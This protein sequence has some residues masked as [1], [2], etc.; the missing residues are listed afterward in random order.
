MPLNSD[1]VE[2]VANTNF[3]YK[4]EIGTDQI[5]SLRE[6]ANAHWAACNKIREA[7]LMRGTRDFAQEDVGEAMAQQQMRTGNSVAE[8]QSNVGLTAML[9]AALGQM[10]GKQGNNTP[11]ETGTK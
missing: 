2:A 8:N 9:V 5:I 4:G 11:P 6:E 7:Y 3:K 10:L 1:V